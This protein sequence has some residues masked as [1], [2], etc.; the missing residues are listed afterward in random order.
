MKKILFLIIVLTA[1]TFGQSNLLLFDNG[2]SNNYEYFITANG[3]K[4]KTTDGLLAVQ[5]GYEY[6]WYFPTFKDYP[7]TP[8]EDFY[9]S[10]SN[11]GKFGWTEPQKVYDSPLGFRDP[12]IIQVNDTFYCVATYNAFANPCTSFVVIKSID[13]YNWSLVG[14]VNI[15]S[16]IPTTNKVWAPEWF[17]DTDGKRY[18]FFSLSTQNYAGWG[19]VD[20]QIYKMENN[21]LSTLSWGTPEKITITG[22]TDVI[23]G[24]M[25]KEN[26]IYYLF[27]ATKGADDGTISYIELATSASL[28]DAFT[29]IG[30]NDWTGFGRGVEGMS[31]HK[32]NNEYI[33]FLDCFHRI[34]S[35]T[36]MAYSTSQS[37]ISGWSKKQDLNINIYH[38][39]PFRVNK[40]GNKL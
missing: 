13:L 11:Y 38:G 21:S 27:Y 14:Y 20:F 15:A 8:D 32:I 22:K 28:A 39:T 2:L 31:V 23:D 24:F 35:R 34:Q 3:E 36:R 5:D 26:N 17:I 29:V 9:L 12:S 33:M 1:L 30:E 10:T 6:T 16:D 40:E 25:Y 18:V 7:D 37:L 4:F 19:G